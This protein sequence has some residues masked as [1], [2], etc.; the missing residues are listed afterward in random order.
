ME[1]FLF[2]LKAWERTWV[3]KRRN[4]AYWVHGFVPNSFLE[5]AGRE[6]RGSW[7]AGRHSKAARDRLSVGGKEEAMEEWAQWPSGVRMNTACI[8]KDNQLTSY[9]PP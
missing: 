9:P 7:E 4:G 5:P 8:V 2:L 1:L 6:G 3:S